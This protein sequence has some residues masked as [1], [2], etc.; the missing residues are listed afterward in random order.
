MVLPAQAL[1]GGTL[2]RLSFTSHQGPEEAESGQAALPPSSAHLAPGCSH[3]HAPELRSGSLHC[4]L[5]CLALPEPVNALRPPR[6][7]WWGAGCSSS[8]T[9]Y[10]KYRYKYYNLV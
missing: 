5:P 2:G 7:P 4:M 10:C 9:L 3:L 8:C 1:S 6:T